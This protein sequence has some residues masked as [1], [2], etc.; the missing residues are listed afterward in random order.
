MFR[1][2]AVID[3]DAPLQYLFLLMKFCVLVTMITLMYASEVY[4]ITAITNSN[5]N[6]NNNN[7][8]SNNLIY[9]APMCRGTSVTLADSSKH[10][11]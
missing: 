11:E 10:A 9:K 3:T 7:N 8:N 5:N 4:H 2:I 6:N 1:V